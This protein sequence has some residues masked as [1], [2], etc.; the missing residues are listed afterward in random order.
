MSLR[1]LAA[2]CALLLAASA[3]PAFAHEPAAPSDD[4]AVLDSVI[5]TGRRDPEDPQVV[6]DARALMARTPGAVAVVSA[7]SYE[8]RFAQGF[9]DSLRN[10]PGVMA[11]KRYGEESRLSIRGSGI[12]QGFHQRGVL[13]AQDGVPFADAD[14]FSDFQGVDQLG[15]RYIEVWKGSNTLRFGGAQLGGAINLVTPT[16]RTAQ[17]ELRLQAEAGS[18]GFRRLHGEAGGVRGDW[19]GFVALTA[20]EA[21]GW[22]AQSDQSQ[23][24]IAANL[25]YSFGDDREVRLIVQAAD[26][27]QSVP[28]ALT[29]NQALTTPRMAPASNILNDNARDQ[30]LKRATL[31]TRWRFDDQTLFEGAVWGWGK[32][33]YHPIFQVVDQQ[34][35]TRGAFARVDWTG[36]VAALKA[37][38]F[39][40]F[41]W[42]DGGLDA[43][44]YVNVGG[45]R[46]ALT[47]KAYQQADGLDVFGEGR[48]FVTEQLALVAGG[49]FGRATRN[50]ADRLDPANDDAIA[51]DWFAPR[52]GLLWEAEDGAQVFANLTRS[53]EPPAYGA[54]VQAPLA[55]FTPVEV[56]DAWTAELGT[57]G[58]RGAFAWDLAVYRS[59]IEGEILSFIVGPDIPA[60]TFNAGRTVHQGIE[61]GLDWRLPSLTGGDLLLRQTYAFSDFRFENDPR[62]GDNRLPVVPRRQYRAEL[63]WRRGGAFVSPSVEWRPQDVWVDYANT[64]KAPSYALLGLNTGFDVSE[65]VAV[66]ADLRNLTDER[67]VG[68]F[69][70]VTDARTAGTAVFYPGEGRSAYVGV[71]VSY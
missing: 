52:L 6:A 8:T 23:A 37:D 7:E 24:R 44:R 15:A 58:R 11:Q 67:Y 19:D 18:Y 29:L 49:S 48:L 66:Y 61:A 32:A 47:A 50:Y 39:Y 54:L 36:T 55:G 22:R 65:G 21:D 14:G 16:G 64:L 3:A 59:E 42:R 26:I 17:D 57:R 34:S 56:Q 13:L 43:L 31:Q 20:M 35:E 27:Q 25:G 70:A 5:V 4:P 28:G 10:V 41:S 69:A 12:A 60:A 33:L 40:G 51:Y 62:W 53:V 9:S 30:T 63:T 2:P 71:R 46:G 1:T 68:E 45:Q 38:A